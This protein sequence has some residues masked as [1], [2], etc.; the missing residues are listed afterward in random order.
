MP[1][2]SRPNGVC[3]LLVVCLVTV[4]PAISDA[5]TFLDR[6]KATMHIGPEA[7][8][9]VIQ[10]ANM[11]D[12]EEEILRDDGTLVIQQPSVWG[13]ARMTVYRKDFEKQMSN[14]LSNFQF[15]L[16]ARVVRTDQATF[17]NQT[18]LAATLT[19]QAPSSTGS[20]AVVTN[21]ATTERDNL[22]TVAGKLLQTTPIPLSRADTLDLLNKAFKTLGNKYGDL[23]LEPPIYLDEEKR[24]LDHLNELRRVNMGDDNADSAG[25]GLYL[26]RLPVSIEPGDK[27]RFN[28]GAIL[29]VTAYHDFGPCFLQQ[30]FRNLVINDLIDQ[31]TPAIYAIV[32]DDRDKQIEAANL[33]KKVAQM[34]HV[35]L[36]QDATNIAKGLITQDM[37]NWMDRVAEEKRWKP[38]SKEVN[39]QNDA[40][41]VAKKLLT[42]K[43]TIDQLYKLTP[44]DVEKEIRNAL[45]DIK[46]K[47]GVNNE[48]NT[49]LVT[50][51][52]AFVAAVQK[53]AR[54]ALVEAMRQADQR[55]Q[56]T[57]LAQQTARQA[58]EKA[59]T[60]VAQT[61]GR[62]ASIVVQGPEYPIAPTDEADV[63]IMDN[64]LA[65]SKAAREMQQ[66]G[67]PRADDIRN[68]LRRE[69]E[70]AYDLMERGV[71]GGGAPLADVPFIQKIV[72]DFRQ[73][74]FADPQL[75]DLWKSNYDLLMHKLN[76]RVRCSPLGPLCWAIAVDAGLLNERL[77][78]DIR[79]QVGANGF[80]CKYAPDSI[81]FY[82]PPSL[83][84]TGPGITA[85]QVFQDY[86][87]A[88]WPLITF[89]L[90]PVVDQQNIADAYS[91][92]RELQLAVA[93][94]F[95]TGR[96]SFNQLNR[97][98]RRIEVDAE[99]IALNRTVT[100]F[101]RGNDTFGWRFTPR[102]Q[103]PP[104]E[105]TNFQ[106]FGD[107]L[108]FNGPPRN[109]QV[110]N[111]KLERGQREL[112]AVI[113][114]PSFLNRIRLDVDGNWFELT[115]PDQLRIPTHRMLRQS[116]RVKELLE[117][118]TGDDSRYRPE[119]VQH[120]ATRLKRLEQMLP[121]QS[122]KVPVPYENALGGFELFGQGNAA[123]VPKLI[124]FEGVDEIEEGQPADVVLYGKS[125]SILETKVVAGGRLMPESGFDILSRQVIHIQIPKDVLPT[126]MEDKKPFVEVYLATPNGISNRVL[127]PFK[128][129]AAAGAGGELFKLGTPTV[130]LRASWVGLG[131]GP[132]GTLA[133]SILDTQTIDLTWAG[134]PTVIPGVIEVKF[135][136]QT[137]DGKKGPFGLLT[138]ATPMPVPVA[139][140]LQKCGK[141]MIPADLFTPALLG[142]LTKQY[143]PADTLPDKVQVT[144]TAIKLDGHPVFYTKA[145]A[146]SA[147]EVQLTVIPAATPGPCLC[148]PAPSTTPLCPPLMSRADDAKLETGRQ[149][150]SSSAPLLSAPRVLGPAPASLPLPPAGRVSLGTPR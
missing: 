105:R 21:S 109:Y 10:L 107:L 31:L 147:L 124:G 67:Q 29:Q 108:L 23:G 83:A 78:E 126:V 85:A 35:D 121:V 130:N 136:F 24:Y 45:K 73:R 48:V 74:R 106:A 19:P 1:S 2:R 84:N 80:T 30:T 150:P 14:E 39:A 15:I 102:Y 43:T 12:D 40:M 3:F 144:I 8:P 28:H 137:P 123:L 112:T 132:S 94:A 53:N 148:P 114:M 59:R 79:C 134:D 122:I 125:I 101:S 146:D 41:I 92:R 82:L 32:L 127:I 27:T 33:V 46:G 117:T 20:T 47:D 61:A 68:F 11:I 49:S 111:S 76:D 57:N 62:T 58:I 69:L 87:K 51:A 142:E 52:K 72:E 99:A 9:T 119:D 93:Y 118:P 90:D 135:D 26:V 91:L 63:F 16:S 97:F 64:L 95:S 38:K 54:P 113:I 56:Q 115:H 145:K 86:V 129:K 71:E 140:P 70:A 103:N 143:K 77:Q 138:N 34:P 128:A 36:I 55:Q 141:Y 88:R 22:A 66:T 149:P 75:G 5:Q 65:I 116:R 4:V 17:E 81:I 120:L 25:Y 96:I 104:P 13:Q 7:P 89:S 42:T 100:V 133:G 60:K 50:F 44:Q 131:G 139:M 98:Q 110:R 18:A 37:K 6:L